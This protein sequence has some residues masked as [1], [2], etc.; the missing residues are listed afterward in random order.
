MQFVSDV[1]KSVG[2]RGMTGMLCFKIAGAKY[3]FNIY[4]RDGLP[5]ALSFGRQKD[6]Q[7]L[8]VL[9]QGSI[10][11]Y[12]FVPNLSTRDQGVFPVDDLIGRT[13]HLQ[14]VSGSLHDSGT[15]SAENRDRE[16]GQV[17]VQ[18]PDAHEPVKHRAPTLPADIPWE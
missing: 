6:G 13:A 11:S 8:D 18:E 17:A 15:A 14:V 10:E 5:Y 7:A 12:H 9:L 1:L 2:E 4:C 3:L 16:P